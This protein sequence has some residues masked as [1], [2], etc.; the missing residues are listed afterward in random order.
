[1]PKPRSILL[2]HFAGQPTLRGSERIAQVL[3]LQLTQRGYQVVLWTNNPALLESVKGSACIGLSGAFD[4]WKA[5]P[6]T[7]RQGI[8][9][10][11]RYQVDLIHAN[12][13]VA[14]ALCSPIAKQLGCKLVGHLH[15]HYN[16][17]D[18]FRSRFHRPN[19][20]ITVSQSAARGLKTWVA[21]KEGLAVIANPVLPGPSIPR[22]SSN[23]F[24]LLTV[25]GLS[26]EKG[27]DRVI[28][29][30]AHLRQNE[31]KNIRLSILGDGP[32]RAALE[33][34]TQALGL[35]EQIHFLGHVK[36]PYPYYAQ[37]DL[38]VMGSRKESFGL[39]IAEAGQYRIP[40]VAPNV[41]GIPEVI[42]HGRHGLLVEGTPQSIAEACSALIYAPNTRRAMG[43][44]AYQRYLDEF[45]L[46]RFG[47][48]IESVYSE[49][50]ASNQ[51]T[52]I[53]FDWRATLS[54]LTKN[55]LQKRGWA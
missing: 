34:Q 52:P 53:G 28:E 19:A 26:R 27:V 7:T 44:A 38:L 24:N 33:A 40:T 39:V 4:A 21:R 25:A 12:S 8:E 51:A 54:E 32:E 37:A 18:R 14:V 5:T 46:R 29:A 48:A 50:F 16:V 41:G 36:D 15:A 43:Q 30:M 13:G 22:Q 6:A 3:A 9:I 49:L 11:R 55:Q 47:D 45:E 42:E 23:T 1:M 20:L 2:C 35:Q 31:T 10:A 17:L